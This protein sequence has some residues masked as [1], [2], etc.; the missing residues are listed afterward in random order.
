[1][2]KDL[3]KALL[4]ICVA[5]YIVSLIDYWGYRLLKWIKGKRDKLSSD[6]IVSLID[7]WLHE[8]LKRIKKGKNEPPSDKS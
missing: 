1:M 7:Y 6:N 8:L 4:F 2:I 3:F 5:I